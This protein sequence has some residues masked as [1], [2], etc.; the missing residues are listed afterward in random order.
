MATADVDTGVY[1]VGNDNVP[2][3][4]RPFFDN[5][6]W[7][8]HSF[9]VYGSWGFLVLAILAHILVWSWRGWIS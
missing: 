7:V 3:V 2:E 1:A 4:Y 6:D 9:T 5:G 8:L